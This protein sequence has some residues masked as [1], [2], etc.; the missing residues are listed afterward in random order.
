MTSVKQIHCLCAVKRIII[1]ELARRL[2]VS[3]QNLHQKLKRDNLRQ[4]NIARIIN[5]LD[6]K[7]EQRFVLESSEKI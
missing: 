1:S 3:S 2:G 5:S 6:I 4:K 7:F